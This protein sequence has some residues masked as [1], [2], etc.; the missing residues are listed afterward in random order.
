M[1][2]RREGIPNMKGRKDQRK[3]KAR[4]SKMRKIEEGNKKK[5]N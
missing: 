3:K 1:K 4:E 2:E 5:K